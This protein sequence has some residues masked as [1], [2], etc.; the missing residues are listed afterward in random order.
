MTHQVSSTQSTKSSSVWSVCLGLLV[1]L[2]VINQL[3]ICN[4]RYLPTR[5][6]ESRL[7]LFKKALKEVCVNFFF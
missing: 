6:D 1:A 4:A 7:E 5:S 2:L 3:T